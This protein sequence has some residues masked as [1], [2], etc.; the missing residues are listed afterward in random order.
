MTVGLGPS[1]HRTGTMSHNVTIELD[2]FGFEQLSRAAQRQGVSLEELLVH[3]SMYYLS[4][5]D[6]GRIATKVFRERV[7]DTVHADGDGAVREPDAPD[8][9]RA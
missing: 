9:D 3:A 7:A 2:D 1:K 5:L 4:D 6:S 8:P